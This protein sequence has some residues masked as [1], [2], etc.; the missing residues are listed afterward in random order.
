MTRYPQP[1]EFVDAQAE[2]DMEKLF[3]IRSKVNS[4]IEQARKDGVV[5][6]SL[7]ADVAMSISTAATSDIIDLLGREEP[8]LK[9]LFGVS[10]VALCDRN[11]DAT[12][13]WQYKDT[14]DVDGTFGP[15]KDIDE[16]V[17]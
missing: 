3:R 12:P 16:Q 4:L 1:D 2:E 8:A 11:L 17:H 15:P 6:S 13:A 5:K 14:L 10:G 9:A 7:S